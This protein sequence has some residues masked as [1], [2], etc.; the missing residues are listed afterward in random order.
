MNCFHQAA[1]GNSN[2]LLDLGRCYRALAYAFMLVHDALRRR[3]ARALLKKHHTPYRWPYMWY[4][5]TFSE[6]IVKPISCLYTTRLKDDA[7][8]PASKT[9]CALA[10][11]LYVQPFSDVIVKPI[12]WAWPDYKR[13]RPRPPQRN[14]IPYRARCL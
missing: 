3:C 14:H 2:L 7:P 4:A 1:L 5:Q 8:A 13:P 12:S 9:Q 10:V 11:A 6:L